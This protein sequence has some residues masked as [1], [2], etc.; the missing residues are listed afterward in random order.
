MTVVYKKKEYR[1]NPF[2]TTNIIYLFKYSCFTDIP[3]YLETRKNLLEN[4]RHL[5]QI[6]YKILKKYFLCISNSKWWT[7]QSY[8]NQDSRTV[9]LFWILSIYD[10]LINHILLI[11]C[12]QWVNVLRRSNAIRRSASNWVTTL[13]GVRPVFWFKIKDIWIGWYSKVANLSYL[14]RYFLRIFFKF[15]SICFRI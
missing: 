11:S 12:L 1:V 2:I 14:R 10:S 6:F 15:W 3:V 9:L 13:K 5:I 8:Q 7:N 4:L